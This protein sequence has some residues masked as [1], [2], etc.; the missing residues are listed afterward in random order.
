MKTIAMYLPQYHIIPENNMWWGEGFT[1]WV[2]VRRAKPLFD[3]HYQ[4]RSP[5]NENYYDLTDVKNLRWQCEIAKK[6]NIY[7][8]CIYHYWFEN[9]RKILEKPAELLLQN[10]D[11]EM[12]FCFCWANQ[13]WARTWSRVRG[14]NAWSDIFEKRGGDILLNQ[15]Y[16]RESQWIEHFEYL[17]DFFADPR[18]I[19]IDD[20]PVFVIYDSDGCSCLP[21]MIDCWNALAREN[22]IKGIYF[23]GENCNRNVNVNG[24]MRHQPGETFSK[25][26]REVVQ[27]LTFFDY[28]D[29]CQ[30]L[31]VENNLWKK[32]YYMGIV[33]FD[34]TPRRGLKGTVIQ[35]I[36]IEAFEQSLKLL[37]EK[38]IR[39]DCEMFFLNAWNEWGE[40][41]YL[42]PD[43][44][45]GFSFLEAHKRAFDSV[46]KQQISK[47]IPLIGQPIPISRENNYYKLLCDWMR[48]K[49]RG[50]S[51][52]DFCRINGWNK[53]A[54]YGAGE[55]G[56]LLYDEIMQSE[57]EVRYFIDQNKTKEMPC[58]VYSVSDK[59]PIVD[60][61][62]ITPYLE[63]T[64]ICRELEKH[65]NLKLVS[66]EEMIKEML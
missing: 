11:I 54:I 9:G 41:M 39:E 20:M 22:G 42:E 51:V 5:L 55:I 28:S 50:A 46:V 43:T 56:M 7:G 25:S 14:A 1:D 35:G 34:D 59:L 49:N 47:E 19:R 65:N 40:G 48:L 13:T 58:A 17:K 33:G 61:V 45:Y 32:Q 15:K 21:E 4:P 60:V 29:V 12:P 8:F 18:Y 66:I 57:M 3:G 2:A 31:D 23:I 30:H 44:K 38:S 6:Y 62:V 24:I 64:Q 52:A 36:N 16:G 26:K 10:K 37:M 63:F 53:I 27:Q